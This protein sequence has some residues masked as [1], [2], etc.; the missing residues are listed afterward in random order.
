MNSSR[1]KRLRNGPL[2]N[3]TNMPNKRLPGLQKCSKIGFTYPQRS[4]HVGITKGPVRLNKMLSMSQPSYDEKNTK[5]S[6]CHYDLSR[7]LTSCLC[8]CRSHCLSICFAILV[9]LFYPYRC[10]CCSRSEEHTSELQS[11]LNLVCR[12]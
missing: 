9:Y 11:H 12:L 1:T 10:L 8:F 3:L 5:N 4:A 7:H 2:I 6:L